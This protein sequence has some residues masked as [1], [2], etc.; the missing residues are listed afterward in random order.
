MCLNDNTYFYCV[1]NFFTYKGP[2]ESNKPPTVNKSVR[3]S[4]LSDVS[5]EFSDIS[6]A[7]NIEGEAGV[8]KVSQKNTSGQRK[9]T[10][11]LKRTPRVQHKVSS[12]REKTE[13]TFSR[14]EP[15]TGVNKSTVRKT[16]VSR[17]N[18]QRK[19]I[20]DR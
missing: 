15:L 11:V 4:V 2:P 12:P 9:P 13:K 8:S 6:E 19:E 18:D 16:N 17:I 10:S 1:F 7:S 20:R 5:N 14:R 3:D